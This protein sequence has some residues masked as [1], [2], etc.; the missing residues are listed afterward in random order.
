MVCSHLLGR[1][2]FGIKQGRHG[3]ADVAPLGMRSGN[4]DQ[5]ARLSLSREA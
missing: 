2:A 1:Q 3:F 5:E 4:V